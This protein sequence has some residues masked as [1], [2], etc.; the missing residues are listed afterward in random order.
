MLNGLACGQGVFMLV[1][2]THSL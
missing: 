1:L 2:N